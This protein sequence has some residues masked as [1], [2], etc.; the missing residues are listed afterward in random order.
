MTT[1]TI[2]FED[3]REKVDDFVKET[4]LKRYQQKQYPM[5]YMGL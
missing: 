1:F 4:N 2:K 3:H 5:R